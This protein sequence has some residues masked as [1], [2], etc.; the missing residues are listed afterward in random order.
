[1]KIF[2]HHAHVFPNNVHPKDPEIPP[3]ASSLSDLC[4]L[5]EECDIDRVVAFAPFP[6][7]YQGVEFHP[8]RWLSNE[9]RNYPSLEGFGTID[10]EKKNTEEQVEEI[11]K[12]DLKG[13]KLHPAVQK[14]SILS[15]KAFRVYETAQDLTLPISFHT[16]VHWYPI[17]ETHP[18]LFDIVAH[19]F[20]RLKF[21]MEHVGGY[22]FFKDAVAVIMNN[23]QGGD[24]R[25]NSNIYAGIVSVLEQTPEANFWY[26]GR[27]KV[28]ELINLV[29]D[30]FLIFGLDFPYRTKTEIKEDIRIIKHMDTLDSSKEKILGKNL[31]KF[32]IP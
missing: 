4:R 15:P 20:P 2:A 5:V 7:F 14:F 19:R 21:S 6:E 29:G 28:K 32:L 25:L 22:H 8:N 1:M 10:F 26:L 18:L 12:L 3:P 13:I 27:E 23:F 9:I 11:K 31:E 16:G 17:K 24:K 30:S